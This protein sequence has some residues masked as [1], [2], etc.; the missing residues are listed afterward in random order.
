MK[1]DAI[2]T[3]ILR[4]LQAQGRIPNNELAAEVGLSPSPCLRRVR[5]LEERGVIMGYTA[6]LDT[7]QIG[8]GFTACSRVTLTGQDKDQVD[9]FIS[10]VKKLKQVVECYIMAG[11][12]DFLLKVVAPDLLAYR[13]FQ[14]GKLSKIRGVQ[15]VKTEIPMEV[16]KS[17]G[18]APL[19]PDI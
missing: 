7:A 10:E 16:I 2:D 9:H 17:F 1:L 19:A 8:M 12:C 13:Q 4:V 14:G 5:L 3:R 6:K 15:N 11:D 18:E